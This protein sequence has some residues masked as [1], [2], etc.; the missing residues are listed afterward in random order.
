MG[1]RH[2]SGFSV[3]NGVRIARND[4]DGKRGSGPVHHPKSLFRGE[5]D[6]QARNRNSHLQVQDDPWL[7]QTV[8]MDCFVFV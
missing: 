6:I 5:V 4:E 3:H 7:E 2:M 8:S 1:W